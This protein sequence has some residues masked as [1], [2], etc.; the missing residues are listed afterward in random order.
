MYLD[1]LHMFIMHDGPVLCTSE[2]GFI[3]MTVII[4]TGFS[5]TKLSDFFDEL[6]HLC[7]SDVYHATVS[8][9]DSKAE[10]ILHMETC[11]E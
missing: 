7:I 10:G 6:N 3:I 2:E 9:L 5:N 11:L 1:L 8:L 4:A